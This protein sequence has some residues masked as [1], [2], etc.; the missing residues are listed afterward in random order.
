MIAEPQTAPDSGNGISGGWSPRLI[1]SLTAIVLLGE[2]LSFSYIMVSMALPT[3][4]ANF[5][6]GQGAWVLTGFLI[7]GSVASPLVGKLADT[8]GKRRLLLAC[9]VISAV[10]W[11]ICALAPSFSVLI[12]GRAIA[13]MMVPTLF[14]SY[15]LIRD[16]FPAKTIALS[17]S[18]ATSGMG[19]IA[20]PAPFLSG[21]LIDTFGFRSVF[22]FGAVGLAVLAVFIRITTAESTVR[23]RSRIDLVGALLLATGIAGVLVAVSFGPTW[24]WADSG[25]MIFLLAGLLLIGAWFWSARVVREPLI[26]LDVLGR[27]PVLLTSLG[28]GFVYGTTSLFTLMLP[29]LAMTP[30]VFG[31]GYGFGVS[32]GGFAIFQTPLGGMIVIGG[33]AVGVLVGRGIR[34]RG[35]IVIGSLLMAAAAVCVAA[36]PDGKVAV[37][38]AAGVFG[39]G[40]GMCYAAIPNLLIEAVPPQLQASTASI[41]GVVQ[42]MLSAVTPVIAFAV[43]NNSFIADL[44]EEMTQGAVVY[45]VGGFQAAFLIAAACAVISALVLFALPRR[46]EQIRVPQAEVREPALV[47]D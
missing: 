45:E 36:V 46:I 23:L 16:V 18:I 2:M 13:G 19:L 3:I 6:T 27:R 11:L 22:W 31:L 42:S 7:V 15:S 25:T 8:H 39:T 38:L 20:I 14:L 34:P 1:L 10:G 4:S 12:V 40:M 17:V 26:D 9:V 35:L 28:A 43:M 5:H 21:W 44:P 30:I 24:G 47:A 37:I 29:M 33:I 41:V 32:A